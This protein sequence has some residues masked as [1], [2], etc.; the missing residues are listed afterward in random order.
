MITDFIQLIELNLIDINKDMKINFTNLFHGLPFFYL[1]F[2]II[3][4]KLSEMI[5]DP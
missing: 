1:F 3:F 4:L 5:S 2:S